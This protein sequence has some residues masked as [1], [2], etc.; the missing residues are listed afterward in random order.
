M[1]S[2]DKALLGEQ[3]GVGVPMRESIY[4]PVL[5]EIKPADH[6]QNASCFATKEAPALMANL[7]IDISSL[8]IES[9][10]TPILKPFP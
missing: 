10:L 2:F 4:C 9:R 8:Q 6:G 3:L 1:D 7:C 5:P